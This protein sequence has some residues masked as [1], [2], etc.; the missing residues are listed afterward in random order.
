MVTSSDLRTEDQIQTMYNEHCRSLIEYWRGDPIMHGGYFAD[1][2]PDASYTTAARHASALLAREAMIDDD[3][4]VL[5]IGCGFGHFLMFIAERFDCV[6]EGLDLSEEHIEFAS[7]RARGN[8]R[9]TFRQ[10]SATELPY[11]QGSFTHVTSQDAF[12]HI[13]NKAAL[14]REIYRV[15]APGGTLAFLDFLQPSKAAPDQDRENTY[16]AL[17]W[18]E[19]YSLLEYQQMLQSVGLEIDLARDLGSHVKQTYHLLGKDTQRYAVTAPDPDEQRQLMDFARVC[20]DVKKG[21][22]R[23]EISWGVIVAHKPTSAGEM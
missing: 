7:A 3:S 15:L 22:D 10:G 6:G 8:P 23:R 13:P 18:T 2:E 11:A 16:A 12:Y 4:R 1:S 19:S 5:D 20:D 14:Y 9:L 21:V 17:G